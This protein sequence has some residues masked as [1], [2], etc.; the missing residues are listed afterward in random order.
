M[1]F[2]IFDLINFSNC[3]IF[4]FSNCLMDDRREF[5]KKASLLSGGAGL[6]SVLPSAVAK[7]LAIDPAAGSTYLDA[8]HVV[9]P[10]AGKP[11]FRSYLW[12]FARCSWI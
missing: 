6:L 7:A 5:L 8:E 4:K 10:N 11:F 12:N 9:F 3:H 2:G 1:R